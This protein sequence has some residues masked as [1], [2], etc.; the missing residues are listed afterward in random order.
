MATLFFLLTCIFFFYEINIFAK[1]KSNHELV[2]KMNEKGFWDSEN[3]SPEKSSLISRGCLYLLMNMFYM[4]WVIIGFALSSQWQFFL[5]LISQGIVQ[6]MIKKI[7]SDDDKVIVKKVNALISI[8]IL[9][10]IFMNHFHPGFFPEK[11]I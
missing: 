1:A 9:G 10:W 7:V 8:V 11:L 5:L 2:T 6:S 4:S 3:G